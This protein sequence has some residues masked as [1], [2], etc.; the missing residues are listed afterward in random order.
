[1][2]EFFFGLCDDYTAHIYIHLLILIN[3]LSQKTIRNCNQIHINVYNKI[4]QMHA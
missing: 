1:M 3:R 2:N 4:K